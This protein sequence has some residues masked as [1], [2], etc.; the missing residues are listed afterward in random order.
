L[1]DRDLV[2]AQVVAVHLDQLQGMYGY[3]CRTF[4]SAMQPSLFV[5]LEVLLE[6][7]SRHKEE[8]PVLPSLTQISSATS[9]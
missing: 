3:D 8:M 4:C 9:R 1:G 7:F 6:G 5:D 2:D